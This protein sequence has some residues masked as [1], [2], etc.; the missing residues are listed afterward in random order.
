VVGLVPAA[1]KLYVVAC[2]AVGERSTVVVV[3]WR[4]R[5]HIVA[6]LD[7]LARQDRPHLTVVVDNASS[8]GTSELLAT[9]PSAPTVLRLPNN[10]GYAGG[11]AS[12]I[13]DVH[14]PYVAWLN[15]DA[16]PEE[17][18]LGALEDALDADPAAGAASAWLVRPD[19]EVQSSG[20]RLTRQGYGADTKTHDV[21]GFCGG[22]AL[23]RT[24]AL[25]AVGG[26]P[27]DFFC[28]YEDTDTSWRLR[29]ADWGILS[30][31]AARARHR[32]GA[33]T[34]LGS[35]SFHLWNERNRLIMLLRCAPGP[36]AARELA[37]FATITAALPIRRLL[38]RTVPD[39]PNFRTALRLRVLGE[40]LVRL[41]GTLRQ[42]QD[43]VATARRPRED[44]W[45]RW[46]GR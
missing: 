19:G 38:G 37:R 26:V 31:P 30:V 40:L 6:C 2:G 29:L 4:S 24:E 43:I 25:R 46:V 13:A 45:A 23:L 18:W 10:Q 41:P 12:A 39:A 17:G 20:V 1:H 9:H 8:D 33:S 3:A 11:L 15:D 36:V 16:E 34:G 42:R 14:T 44:V 32:H 27:A 35:T 21:F 5:E 22:A 28:Y 7:A